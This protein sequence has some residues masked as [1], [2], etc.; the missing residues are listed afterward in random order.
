MLAAQEGRC[1]KPLAYEALHY[2]AYHGHLTCVGDLSLSAGVPKTP[3]GSA[4]FPKKEGCWNQRFGRSF[5]GNP[6]LKQVPG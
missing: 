4:D 6:G 2:A 1:D 3:L 5:L